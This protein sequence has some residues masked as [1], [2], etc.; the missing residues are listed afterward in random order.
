MVDFGTDRG[1]AFV[2]T[3]RNVGGV[4]FGTLPEQT[5]A[6]GARL[7]KR[8]DALSCDA[9]RNP[10]RHRRACAGAGVGRRLLRRRRGSASIAIDG[11]T[12]RASKDGDGHATHVLSA[13]C[14]GLQSILGN[15]ASRGKGMEI[16][17]ALKLLDQLDLKDKI[18]TGDA[19]F[20]QKSIVAKIAEKGGGYVF[21]VKDNQKNLRENIATAFNEP[22][23]PPRLV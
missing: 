5:P 22:V 11:K 16:P 8:R 2:R 4:S 18:V 10:A 17:D 7:Y 19:M 21:P 14:A 1:V 20:C 23:F 12:M 6:R 15:E 9:Y 13:F 3:T